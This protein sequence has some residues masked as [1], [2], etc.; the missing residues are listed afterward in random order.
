MADV[1]DLTASQAVKALERNELSGDEYL[2][3]WQQ[4]AAGDELNA[5][6]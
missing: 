5:Y 1:L 6:L 4:A 2:A 3:A